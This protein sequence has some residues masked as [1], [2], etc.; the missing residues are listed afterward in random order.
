M[1]PA[2]G[3]AYDRLGLGYTRHRHPDPRVAARIVAALGG[4]RTVVNVGAGAGAY[5]PVDRRLVA[6]EPSSVMLRQRSRD[7]AAAVQAVGEHLPFADNRFDA[8]MA[9]L[10]IHHWRDWRA[11]L[12]ELRRVARERVVL[13]HFDLAHQEALWLVSDYLPEALDIPAPTMDDVA[14]ALDAPVSVEIVPVPR[15]CTDGFMCAYWAR[16]EAYLDPAVRA[17]ISTFHVLD[18]SVCERAIAALARDLESGTWDACHG[19]LRD[20]A[21]LDA[22]YRI[23]V[24]HL[25]P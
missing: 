1:T 14:T 10:T 6:V 12:G 24:A 11:G 9:S 15:D 3:T 4:A 21:E 23:V 5:E 8:S 25:P 20:L 18:Q 16:P 22:G 2:P 19:H 17:A 7:A 13:F